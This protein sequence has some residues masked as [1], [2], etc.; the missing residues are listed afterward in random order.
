M[1]K[2]FLFV[3]LACSISCS[4][5]NTKLLEPKRSEASISLHANN[6]QDLYKIFDQIT[7]TKVIE[8][9]NR[10]YNLDKPLILNSLNHITVNG[11]GAVLVLDSL[12]NDVVVMNK[13]H[14]ITIDNIKALHKEP[15]GPVGCTGNVI[16]INGGSN[17]TI[18]NSELN[19][20]GVV[21]VS[22]YTSRNL[23]IISNYIHKNTHYPIIYK[24]PSV[25][26]QDNKFEN[27]G[28]ENKIAYI[29]DST[30]PPKKFFNTNV[31]KNGI[32]IE[33]NIFIESQ[34]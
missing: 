5:I 12:V 16:L 30:W 27:N 17:I 9:K 22:A 28:N 6:E 2:L 24:G 18:I 25:T 29:G 14:N 1:I 19:G 11:N 4:S 20:C 10:I 26:I 21:G 3:I 33:G 8:L 23:K 7:D 34:P 32:I 31:T 13:C 15:D